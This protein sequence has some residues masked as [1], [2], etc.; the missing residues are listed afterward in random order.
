MK[1]TRALSIRQPYAEL[2]MTGEKVIEYRT[3]PTNIRERVY[4]YAS[5]KVFNIGYHAYGINAENLVRGK[6]IGTVEIIG[7]LRNEDGGYEWRLANAKR[8]RKPLKPK[9][10][11]QPVW[12]RP[13]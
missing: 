5:K 7:C 13:F 1:I 6:I 12:F 2:V 4:I 11:P 8:L 10:K 9:N 3:V